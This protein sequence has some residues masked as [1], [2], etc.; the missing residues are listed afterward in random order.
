M[1]YYQSMK[2]PLIITVLIIISLGLYLNR[3]YAHI[4]HTIDA[5]GL[6]SSAKEKEYVITK[7]DATSTLK[8]I[9]IGDSLTSG[10]GVSDYMYSYPYLVGQQLAEDGHTV[11]V[12]NYSY[13]GARTKGIIENLLTSA[14]EDKADVITLLIGVNDIHGKISL[15]D[16]KENYTRILRELKAV[17]GAKINAVNIPF[18]GAPTLLRFPYQYYFDWRTKQFNTIIQ[19]LAKE[20]GIT[21]IDLYSQTKSLFKKSGTHYSLDSFHPSKEGYAVWSKVIYAGLNP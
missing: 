11:V 13:P 12:K 1:L 2:I 20:F 18:I 10:V 17:P 15:S 21:Y 8:Y 19:G 5:A 7:A 6:T 16:F 9:A 14:V 4:Y 3:S